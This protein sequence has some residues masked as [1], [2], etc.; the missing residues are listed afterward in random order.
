MMEKSEG[1]EYYGQGTR[2][3]GKLEKCECDVTG[4]D[5]QDCVRLCG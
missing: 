4:R 2:L 5:L 1:R 3:G